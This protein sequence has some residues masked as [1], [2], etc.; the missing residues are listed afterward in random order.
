MVVN[1]LNEVRLAYRVSQALR[2][3]ARHARHMCERARARGDYYAA[4]WHAA[5]WRSLLIEAIAVEAQA[6]S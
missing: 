1:Q 3:Q 4:D 5:G 2:L 6:R